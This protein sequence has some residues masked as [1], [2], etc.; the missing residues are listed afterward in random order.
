M[1]GEVVGE[2]WGGKEEV[3]KKW[4]GSVGGEWWGSGEGVVGKWRSNRESDKGM[5]S[6]WWGSDRGNDREVV[7][8]WWGSDGRN[9]GGSDGRIFREVIY[10]GGRIF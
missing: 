8:K 4:C 9:Y 10:L 1:M 7:G 6:K 3:V 2:W 5:M